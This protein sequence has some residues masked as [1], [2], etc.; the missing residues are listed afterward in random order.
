MP[1]SIGLVVPII[2]LLLV[3]LYFHAPQNR[4][5]IAINGAA[6]FA[7]FAML[8]LLSITVSPVLIPR[9]VLPAVVPLALLLGGG[10]AVLLKGRKIG[11]ALLV[12]VF[13]ELS[14]ATIYYHRHH[15]SGREAWREASLYLQA[16]AKDGECVL[17]FGWMALESIRRYDRLGKLNY[18][19]VQRAGHY[20][21]RDGVVSAN[22]FRTLATDLSLHHGQSV[23]VVE[24]MSKHTIPVRESV[25]KWTDLARVQDFRNVELTKFRVP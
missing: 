14:V 9:T 1:P 4:Q 25:R 18:L 7:P 11:L 15:H 12:I 20:Q 23:W 6:F 24:R 2:A 13:A 5:S 16:E 3:V 17:A 19:C 22:R 10:Q 21:A 8:F